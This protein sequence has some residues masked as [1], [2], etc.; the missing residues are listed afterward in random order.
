MSGRTTYTHNSK[1][2]E[3]VKNKNFADA[4]AAIEKWFQD[5]GYANSN[6]V[7]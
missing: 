5:N 1:L 7:E 6:P 4:C 3:L 2:S